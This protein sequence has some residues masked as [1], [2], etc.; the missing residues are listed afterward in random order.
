MCSGCE[1]GVHR[2][3]YIVVAARVGGGATMQREGLC[4][5]VGQRLR[6]GTYAEVL[7]NIQQN[8][9]SLHGVFRGVDLAVGR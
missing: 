1:S 2:I 7:P 6:T 5:W 4:G 8:F 3:P 9:R